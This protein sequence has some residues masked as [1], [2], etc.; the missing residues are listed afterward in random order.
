[1]SSDLHNSRDGYPLT[2]CQ[3]HPGSIMPTLS[4]FETFVSSSFP[5]S[6]HDAGSAGF[7]GSFSGPSTDDP[8]TFNFS[9][10][11]TAS[12]LLIGAVSAYTGT[13]SGPITAQ[14]PNPLCF[15]VY[16]L[17]GSAGF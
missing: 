14:F 10:S 17:A 1:M 6:A 3:P 16:G 12:S 2:L 11:A 5:G 13:P 4:H 9:L 7:S 15:V 8:P